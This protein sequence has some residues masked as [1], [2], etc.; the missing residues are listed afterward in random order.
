MTQILNNDILESG[1]Q[2]IQIVQ[3]TLIDCKWIT[4]V[5]HY[6]NDQVNGIEDILITVK[7]NVISLNHTIVTLKTSVKISIGGVLT[8]LSDGSF[9][10][11]GGKNILNDEPSLAPDVKNTLET[12]LEQ[13][14]ILEQKT[15]EKEK[16]K[17]KNNIILKITKSSH[18][19]VVREN[20]RIATVL[21]EKLDVNSTTI[22]T[23]GWPH[24]DNITTG[25]WGQPTTFRRGIHLDTVSP[26]GIYTA[27][28][29]K[30]WLVNGVCHSGIVCPAIRHPD[31]DIKFVDVLGRDIS[32]NGNTML[33]TSGDTGRQSVSRC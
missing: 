8:C 19:S 16:E 12:K 25:Y 20:Q 21:Y 1:D 18:R 3:I 26:E 24:P 7:S 28:E 29:F 10:G 13:N 4:D 15:K 33:I 9:I 27:P 11:P 32:Y 2:I 22:L 14:P 23:L 6:I 5:S 17:Q 31:P 30:R